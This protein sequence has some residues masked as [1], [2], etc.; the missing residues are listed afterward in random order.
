[1]VKSIKISCFYCNSRRTTH[2]KKTPLKQKLYFFGKAWFDP[3]ATRNYVEICNCVC[4][5]KCN[6]NYQTIKCEKEML[7][8]LLKSLHPTSSALQNYKNIFR[9][10]NFDTWSKHITHLVQPEKN[11]LHIIFKLSK[12]QAYLDCRKIKGRFVIISVEVIQ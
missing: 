11:A 8:K 1:M 9:I 2:P 4:C 6:R 12:I 5:C 7:G 10:N 3:D